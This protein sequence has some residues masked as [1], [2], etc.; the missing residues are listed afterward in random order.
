MKETPNWSVLD[1][2]WSLEEGH[3]SISWQHDEQTKLRCSQAWVSEPGTWNQQDNFFEF[4]LSL[5]SVD[6]SCPTLCDPIDCSMT[7]FPAWSLLKLMSIKL[8]IP[9]NH[10]TRHWL[11]SISWYGLVFSIIQKTS[12]L[13]FPIFLFV[14]SVST[15]GGKVCLQSLDQQS[16]LYIF[17]SSP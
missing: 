7:G 13:S 4:L 5:S 15:K 17:F 1:K 3:G 9:S 10:L 8:V 11:F 6:Q 12:M 14:N 16:G 2:M